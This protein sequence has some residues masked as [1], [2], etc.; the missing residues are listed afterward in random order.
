MG[1]GAGTRNCNMLAGNH[2]FSPKIKTDIIT[3]YLDSFS[4]YMLA[5]QNYCVIL[6]G[7]F[8]VPSFD[9]NYGLEFPKHRIR[10]N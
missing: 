4:E 9:C 3:T 5:A 2:Y 7:D 6:V 10:L 8:N 1:K